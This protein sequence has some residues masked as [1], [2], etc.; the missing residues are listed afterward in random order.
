[1]NAG[2]T[3][4]VAEDGLSNRQFFALIA[5]SLWGTQIWCMPNETT[6]GI[7]RDGD[8][9]AGNDG[10]AAAEVKKTTKQEASNN[11]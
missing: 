9:V 3:G 6:L 8:M 2:T 7:D 10:E 4:L 5:N 11:V 1:M